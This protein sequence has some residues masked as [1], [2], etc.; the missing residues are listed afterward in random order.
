MESHGSKDKEDSML[1]MFS[2]LKADAFASRFQAR[3]VRFLTSLVG[4][5]HV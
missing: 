2:S 3:D 4:R 5:R 1:H